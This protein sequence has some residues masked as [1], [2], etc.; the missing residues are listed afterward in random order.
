DA[1]LVRGRERVADL[2]QDANGARLAE[3]LFEHEQLEEV[4]A[5]EE[6]HRDV[7]DS[8][9]DAG[10]DDAHRVRVLDLGRRARFALESPDERGA[11]EQ[12]RVHDLD[13]DVARLGVLYAAVDSGHRALAD[14]PGYPKSAREGA[15]DEGAAE[16]HRGAKV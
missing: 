11:A 10:V 8:I 9:V 15:A 2:H 3:P 1:L 7:E 5:S 14:E 12:V 16:A 13:G 4:L 6:L